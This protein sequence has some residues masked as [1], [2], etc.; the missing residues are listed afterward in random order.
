MWST[1]LSFFTDS[2]TKL[3]VYLGIALVLAVLLGWLF[4]SRASLKTDLAEA[5]ANVATLDAANKAS[6]AALAEVRASDAAKEKALAQRE[7]TIKTISVQRETLRRKLGEALHNDP[8]TC[9]WADTALPAAVRG[10]LQ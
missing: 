9:S 7:A 3:T 10:L 4:W 2:S 5:N 6:A 1:I 8:E